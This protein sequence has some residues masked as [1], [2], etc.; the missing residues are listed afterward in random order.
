[1]E[2][3]NIWIGRLSTGDCPPW[4]R[5]PYPI[6]WR[7]KYS[8]KAEF[9]PWLSS[10]WNISLLLLWTLSLRLELTSSALLIICPSDSDWN[11][12]IGSFFSLWD[13]ESGPKQWKCWVLTT[14]LAGNSQG[15]SFLE[16][17][18]CQLQSL[19]PLSLHICVNHFLMDYPIGLFLWR[20]Q[21]HTTVNC[22]GSRSLL[23]P[24]EDS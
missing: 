4:C 10:S 2:E 20:T 16:S 17:L 21:I 3:F 13:L 8:K 24:S 5:W 12:T 6:H 9:T 1:M 14:G 23:C 7:C 22:K 15:I 19:G 11:Y 18:A